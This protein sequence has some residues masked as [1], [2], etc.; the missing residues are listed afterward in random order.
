MTALS[1]PDFQ[2]TV[3]SHFP[4]QKDLTFNERNSHYQAVYRTGWSSLPIHVIYYPQANP[5]CWVVSEGVLN[6]AGRGETLPAA[7]VE[8]DKVCPGLT[9]A[10]L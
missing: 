3:L 2:E 7:L 6:P 10:R 9:P 1:Y 8:F 4:S 5:P